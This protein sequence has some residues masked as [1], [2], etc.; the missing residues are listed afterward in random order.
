[1]EPLLTNKQD[2]KEIIHFELIYFISTIKSIFE[3]IRMLIFEISVFR[4]S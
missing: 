3:R 2:L 1:M 4:H